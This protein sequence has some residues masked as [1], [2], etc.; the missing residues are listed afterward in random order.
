MK[1]LAD[2]FELEHFCNN[3]SFMFHYFTGLQ[4]NCNIQSFLEESNLFHAMSEKNRIGRKN[5]EGCKR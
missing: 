4:K 5:L 1:L 3:S 2:I